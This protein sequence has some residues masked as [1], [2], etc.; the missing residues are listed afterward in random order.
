M[1]NLILIFLILSVVFQG[2]ESVINQDPAVSGRF[3]HIKENFPDPPL[4]YSTAPFW[5][6][7]DLVTRE[8]IDN[9]LHSFKENG[10]HQVFIHPRPGLINEYLS[11]EW[12]EL[13]TYAVKKAKQLNMKIWLY[14]ENSFPSGFA[15]GH[16]PAS[17]PE[18]AD[19]V[20]G[21]KLH[22]LNRLVEEELHQYLIILKRIGNSFANISSGARNYLN[23]PGDYYAF[24]KW[25]Y[26]DNQ[27]QFGGF[28][29]VDLLAYGITERFIRI[30]MKGYRDYLGD[31]WGGTIPGIFTD[32]PHI[33]VS[34]DPT[35]IK[36]T[37]VLF[38]QF[39]EVYGYPLENYL[40]CLYEEIGDW[41][42]V[43]HDYYALL[44]DMF[45]E[46]WAKP[47]YFYTDT[48]NLKWTGHYWEHTWPNPRY[49]GDNMAMYAWHQYPGIDLLFNNERLRPDQFGNIR[50][51]K[52]LNSVANQL[53]KRRTL[54]EIYGASG[55][56]LDFESMKRLG[57]W[58]Y[59]L[60]VNMM[61]P[62]LS[63]MTIKGARKRDFPQSM[64]YHAPWWDN[65]KPLNEYFHRLSYIMSAGEQINSILVMEPTSTTWM[66]FSPENGRDHL[67]VAGDLLMIERS[68]RNLLDTLEEHQ[69]EYDLG[70]EN[71]M[72]T[73]GKVSGNFLE[74]GERKYDL[75]ILPPGF[76]NVEKT[77]YDLLLSYLK[78]GGKIL[79]F[80]NKP[81]YLAGNISRTVKD[82][83][84]QFTDNWTVI[85]SL[86]QTVIDKFLQ[87][88]EFMPLHPEQWGGRVFHQRRKLEDGQIIFLTNYDTIEDARIAFKIHGEMV[89]DLDLIKGDIYHVETGASEENISINFTLPP[90]GSRLLF[91][92]DKKI[93]IT[94]RD[95]IFVY[96]ITEMPDPSAIIRNGPNTL[97]LDYCR[98]EIDDKVWDNIY[99]YAA[100]DTVFKK[101][102]GP[103]Y[104]FNHNPWSIGIQYRSG[105]LDA[106][107]FE[108]NTGFKASYSFRIQDG[109][110]PGDLRAVIE[111][112]Q[113]YQVYINN[114]KIDPLPGKWWLDTSFGVFDIADHVHEGD[115][116]LRLEAEP[117]NLLAELE[118]VY[119][120]GN[121]SVRPFEKGWL[122]G[123]DNTLQTGSWKDQG[124]PF[125]SE[126]VSY[127]HSTNIPE[128]KGK[129]YSIN[130]SQWNGTV[131]EVI[132]NGKKAG[133]IGWQPYQC[134]ITEWLN[135]GENTIE[136][137][138]FGSLKNLLG[139]HH[140]N[141]AEGVVTPWSF[142]YA[143]SHQPPGWDYDLVDYGLFEEV[144]LLISTDI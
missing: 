104:G 20:A 115:N 76:E 53:N 21:L 9:Q 17:I 27:G 23:D 41:K 94:S 102:F 106:N 100:A 56:E 125:Y 96:E 142:F 50:V 6:W 91:I 43:R 101:Y 57:D 65:Y 25:Y 80:K 105:I 107:Q 127:I 2:C 19:M 67:G 72:A 126:S 1:K 144:G 77:T 128:T 111:W 82:S 103:V 45:I 95:N 119:I 121:F 42:N 33:N 39:Q 37:P 26:P 85:D 3:E 131:A 83:F 71:I 8:K 109:F 54:A 59:V 51:V 70:C 46:R 28:S 58:A 10:I 24:S 143:P 89:I 69:V 7:N 84:D 138:I 22:K 118:P 60:G 117:M 90:A 34:R 99:F 55:W 48:N 18:N 97:S 92:S 114:N 63:F 136:V 134:H 49:G 112:P 78:Q 40:P 130:L 62:H 74:I 132:V 141:P 108:E 79:S 86:D 12:F 14:D 52:E 64:S 29:Y 66:Y 98:L 137:K 133:I 122:L 38:N 116:M 81:Q 47:W 75:I 110:I 135:P 93:N 124:M 140:N 113:L 44:L 30:T 88:D 61:N 139:P 31:E 35:V 4:E 120:T 36:Y 73:H 13:C 68:F 16:V 123:E 11:K 129:H 5:V 87:N 15:G 32:E